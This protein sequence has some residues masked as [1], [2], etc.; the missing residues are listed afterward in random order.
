M[1]TDA[2]G[3]LLPRRPLSQPDLQRFRQ[4][5]DQQ[6]VAAGDPAV[7]GAG[8]AGLQGFVKEGLGGNVV[9][10]QAELVLQLGKRLQIGFE[11]LGREQGGKELDGIA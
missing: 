3:S 6:C 1:P 9:V 2:P 5:A 10:D 4:F 7:D 11:A 8:R